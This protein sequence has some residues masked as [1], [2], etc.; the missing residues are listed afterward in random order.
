[1]KEQ[2]ICALA[3]P[4]G[5]GGIAIL[6]MS[7]EDSL[8][9]A[10]QIFDGRGEIL[11][12]QMVLG[13][14]RDG[15]TPVDQ[16]LLVY[17]AAPASY[18]GEDVVEIHC[19][20]GMMAA[21]MILDLLMEKGAVPAQPGEF[22]K[23]A[24]L[25]GKMDLSQA[26]AVGELI[27]S[28]S[29]K[30][31]AVSARQLR[32]DLMNKIR[33]LQDRLTDCIAA[34]EAGIEYPEEDLEEAI[35]QAQMPGLKKIEK[36]LHKLLSSYREGRMLREGIQVAIAGRPNVGKSSLLNAI[37]GEEK[38]IVTDIPGTT[39][40]VVKEYR[41]IHSVPVVFLDTAGIRETQDAVEKIGVERSRAALADCSLILFLLDG[42]ETLTPE[43]S[44]IFREISRQEKPV[45]LVLNKTDL[46]R[47]TTAADVVE[48]FG[49][50][51]MEIS[52][53]TGEGIDAL[54]EEVY[55]A[56][57][58]DEEMLEGVV[59][60]EKRHQAA[61][62]AASDALGDAIR[63]LEAGVD[64]DCASIDLKACW[65]RLGEI[66]GETLGEEIIDRIFTKFCLGK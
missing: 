53:A 32:G 60:T 56:A 25:H 34:L 44:D 55:R 22:T 27:G 59:I 1:M 24:F 14:I 31:A 12:R 63:A 64:L 5:S 23:R 9:I 61:L 19:H 66:T 28:L 57:I 2:T 18:T 52:A 20:G 6:R 38:A 39:R 8:P 29:K 48:A 42:A 58:R 49:K 43:D 30:G 46:N 13:Y 26:E 51:P 33:E 41:T 16:V 3:T 40:D 47:E 45:L 17:F 4:A 36:E 11:P 54:L 21:Q 65:D 10:K 7:G 62:S 37:F 15:Q 50:A 35:L